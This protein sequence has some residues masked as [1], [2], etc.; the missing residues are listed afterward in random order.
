MDFKILLVQ[1]LK[2][3]GLDFIGTVH[4][5]QKTNPA[6]PPTACA[7]LVHMLRGVLILSLSLSLT[8][9]LSFDIYLLGLYAS[10]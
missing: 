2:I 1:S 7:H 9:S 5:Q 10:C 4:I 8:F 3:A 6:P